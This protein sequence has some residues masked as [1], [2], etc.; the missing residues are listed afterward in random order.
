MLPFYL[1][2]YSSLAFSVWNKLFH[3]L[4]LWQWLTLSNP[5]NQWTRGGLSTTAVRGRD[6][7]ILRGPRAWGRR[8]RTPKK[9]PWAQHRVLP[10]LSQAKLKETKSHPALLLKTCDF[11]QKQL[12]VIPLGRANHW[13]PVTRLSDCMLAGSRQYRSRNLSMNSKKRVHNYCRKSCDVGAEWV[14]SSLHFLFSSLLQF[15]QCSRKKMYY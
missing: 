7:G 8:L 14:H 5:A 2:N 9:L 11:F 13:D 1:K 10:Y 12:L 15:G 6:R 3:S 4:R